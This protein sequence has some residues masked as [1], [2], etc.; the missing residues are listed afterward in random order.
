MM[1]DRIADAFF[2]GI[3]DRFEHG[4]LRAEQLYR[5]TWMHRAAWRT[6]WELAN[7]LTARPLRTERRKAA[8]SIAAGQSR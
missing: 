5:R 4:L 6:G 2:S 1:M 8:V 3:N 7:A